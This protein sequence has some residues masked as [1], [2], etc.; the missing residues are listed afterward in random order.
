MT[1][2][3]SIAL[4]GWIDSV[5]FRT[6][7]VRYRV[8]NRGYIGNPGDRK[9]RAV[10]K[11]VLQSQSPCLDQRHMVCSRCP[12]RGS[13]VFFQLVVDQ[14]EFM[15]YIVHI[16]DPAEW[17]GLTEPGKEQG[18]DIRVIGHKSRL[19]DQIAGYLMRKPF[20]SFDAAGGERVWF[21]LASVDHKY[22]GKEIRAGDLIEDYTKRCPW[23]GDEI[24]RLRI[25][26]VTPV[27]IRQ[28]G[29]IMG[30]PEDL[31]FDVFL[32]ALHKRIGGLAKAYCGFEGRSIPSLEDL[33]VGNGLIRTDSDGIRFASLKPRAKDCPGEGKGPEYIG[34]FKGTLSFKGNLT[35]YLYLIL[36]GEALHIGK[37]TTQGLGHY[38]I[39]GIN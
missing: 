25:E 7:H 14:S 28:A 33:G 26:F 39:R 3:E 23:N 2:K 11:A 16:D 17:L 30:R 24:P 18:F 38:R 31:T 19:A 27:E 22:G 1:M 10:L 35:P 20:F 13:C 21:E 32:K 6:I 9:I 37:K 36:L 29:K 34:G 8:L 4:P 12:Q 5:Y 15:P